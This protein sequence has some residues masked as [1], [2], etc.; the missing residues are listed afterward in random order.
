MAK[1]RSF[2]NVADVAKSWGGTMTFA[3]HMKGLWLP[4]WP[5]LRERVTIDFPVTRCSFDAVVKDVTYL[6]SP[7]DV[8]ADCVF[9]RCGPMTVEDRGWWAHL[10]WWALRMYWFGRALFRGE[11][12][13]KRG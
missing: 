6:A 9:S 11:R 1:V 4:T 10:R 2:S 7:D 8:I 13:L 5:P 12:V 3:M